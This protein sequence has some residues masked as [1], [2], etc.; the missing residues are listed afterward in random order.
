MSLQSISTI[1]K[2]QMA[3]LGFK[4][5]DIKS[6]MRYRKKLSVID[7]AEMNESTVD[8]RTLHGQIDVKTPFNDW[9]N[10][11]A[12]AMRLIQGRDFYTFLR[13]SSGGRPAIEYS[14]TLDAAKSIAMSAK[15]D[16]GFVIREYFLL[17][18]RLLKHMFL[19]NPFRALSLKNHERLKAVYESQYKGKVKP[20][21][22][23]PKHHSLIAV[24]STGATPAKWR[25][26]GYDNLQNFMQSDEEQLYT[27]VQELVLRM[28]E[29]GKDYSEVKE[30]CEDLYPQKDRTIY[31]KYHLL[32]LASANDDEDVTED[33]A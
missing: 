17:C 14:L 1:S 16:A 31:K 10:N 24:T 8:A 19:Y 33:A 11:K 28:L 26:L 2:K 25:K 6:V 7:D 27:S 20:E 22:F 12:K 29:A 21:R 32:S 9:I 13:E 5:D 3:V 18:E 4:P 23:F 15:T 30:M